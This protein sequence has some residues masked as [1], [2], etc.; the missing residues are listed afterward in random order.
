MGISNNPEE[1]HRR[2]SIFS[3]IWN[4]SSHTNQDKFVQCLGFRILPSQERGINDETIGL[5]GRVPGVGDYKVGRIS[6][7]TCSKIQQRREEK[8]VWCRRFGTSEG[9]RK[10]LRRQCRKVSTDLGGT[11]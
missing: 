5:V 11:I 3:N 4:G 10:H 2:D 1:I 8:G 6:A 7:K 9:S